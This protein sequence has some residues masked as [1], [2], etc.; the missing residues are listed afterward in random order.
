MP[1]Q[2]EMIPSLP[3]R[4]SGTKRWPGSKYGTR[5][6]RC[7]NEKKALKSMARSSSA[8]AQSEKGFLPEKRIVSRARKST[9]SFTRSKHVASNSKKANEL[10]QA[11]DTQGSLKMSPASKQMTGTYY[12]VRSK[13]HKSILAS[14]ERY[15]QNRNASA[16][17][18]HI[19]R[20]LSARNI[21]KQ[22]L[23]QSVSR[24]RKEEPN[25]TMTRS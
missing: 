22:P 19:N 17:E 5:E 20:M 13:I 8:Y 15:G 2:P 9:G 16:S 23:E 24:E 7:M 11:Y 3:S 4:G 12:A 14:N 10:R 6:Q 21:K 18:K 1:P 25:Q